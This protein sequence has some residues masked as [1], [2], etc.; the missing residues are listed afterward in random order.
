[1]TAP[2][3][4]AL[5]CLAVVAVGVG[6]VISNGKKSPSALPAT[7]APKVPEIP[8]APAAPPTLSA[9][10]CADPTPDGPSPCVFR[11]GTPLP[12]PLGAAAAT[13]AGRFVYVAGG[14]A[15]VNGTEGS[16]AVFFAPLD[17][18]GAI[19]AWTKTTPY[20]LDVMQQGFVFHGG[21]LYGVGGA[22]PTS[23]NNLVQSAVYFAKVNA[24]G[25]I[26][27]WKAGPDLPEPAG[28]PSVVVLNDFLYVIGGYSSTGPGTTSTGKVY[29]SSFKRDGSLTGWK[30]T[31]SLTGARFFATA[32]AG[33]STIYLLGGTYKNEGDHGPFQDGPK[34]CEPHRVL[35][36]HQNRD[37]TLTPW[38]AGT[39]YANP[40]LAPG[41]AVVGNHLVLVQS[42]GARQMQGS[43]DVL[44]APIAA[45]G[46]I[47]AWTVAGHLSEIGASR[48]VA[49]GPAGIYAFGGTGL[50]E[51]KSVLLTTSAVI[52]VANG[53][54][55]C[56]AN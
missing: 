10:G 55:S 2:R 54:L 11:T 56:P 48:A 36:T 52:P 44:S 41:A 45:D 1:M 15:T 24:D 26:G 6:L 19:G 23:D 22:I 12:I 18:K 49:F 4:F 7:P 39:P 35:L 5:V 29:F 30:T 34:T 37:G 21:Y 42:S 14:A 32:A 50:E 43:S 13:V 53:A 17:A 38:V 40:S 9:E 31:T 8:V 20:P 27:A 16:T 25:T 46:S 33:P 3:Q 47:G 28:A 51:L